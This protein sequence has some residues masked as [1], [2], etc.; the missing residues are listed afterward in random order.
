MFALVD[1]DWAVL[2][3]FASTVYVSWL[4][5]YT[6]IARDSSALLSPCTVCANLPP[7]RRQCQFL[8]TGCF[9]VGKLFSIPRDLKTTTLYYCTWCIRSTQ[10]VI[11]LPCQCRCC[12]ENGHHLNNTC[13]PGVLC[14][15]LST[16]RWSCAHLKTLKCT[17]F[18][19]WTQH[20]TIYIWFGLQIFVCV[21]IFRFKAELGV[22]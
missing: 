5:W 19:L 10:S 13:S 4:H 21:S 12:V 20:D 2:F 6:R 14:W 1:G 9:V 15:F 7:A 3:G 8:T 22:G 11:T 17:S 18:I 16:S